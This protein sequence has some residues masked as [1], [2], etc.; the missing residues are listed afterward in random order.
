MD[1]AATEADESALTVSLRQHK[2]AKAVCGCAVTHTLDARTL[3]PPRC[4]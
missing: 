2:A 4:S 3:P 1:G